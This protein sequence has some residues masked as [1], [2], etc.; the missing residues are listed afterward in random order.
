MTDFEDHGAFY[1]TLGGGRI[2]GVRRRLDQRFDRCLAVVESHDGGLLRGGHDCPASAPVR[3]MWTAPW[4]ALFCAERVGRLRSYV[5]P[6][7]AAHMSAGPDEVRLPESLSDLRASSS[8]LTTGCFWSSVATVSFIASQCAYQ[9][10]NCDL[11][12]CSVDML[13]GRAAS[14]RLREYFGAEDFAGSHYRPDDPGE[15]VGQRHRDEACRLFRQKRANPV[16]ERAFAL[17]HATQQ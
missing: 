17:A 3:H 13:A 7:G 9:T 5:R 11:Y 12:N 16:G 14:L 1:L 15:L 4:Q 10:S 6:G 2:A 8:C